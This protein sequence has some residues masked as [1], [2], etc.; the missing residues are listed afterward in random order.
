MNKKWY[1]LMVLLVVVAAEGFAA[2]KLSVVAAD[3]RVERL[4]GG[5]EFTEGAAADAGEAR[6]CQAKV[7]DRGRRLSPRFHA[8][9]DAGVVS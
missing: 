2:E 4:C 7:D 6:L 5:F 8:R 1:G 3:A 9:H